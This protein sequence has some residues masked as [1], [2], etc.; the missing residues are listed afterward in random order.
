MIAKKIITNKPL[1]TSSI[2]ILF[3]ILYVIIFEFTWVTQNLF[4]KPT[5]L[6]ES[7]MSLL[8]EYNLVDAFF[9]TTAVI[10]PSILIA[11]LI[12][13]IFSKIFLSVFID[14][15]GI[16]NITTPFKYFSFFFFAL[17][18][19][20]L[21]QNS[22]FVEF[23]FTILFV[24]GLLLQIISKETDSIKEE[25]VIAAKSLGLSS[26]QIFSQVIW[27]SLKPN[28]YG[29]L[30]SIHTGAWVVVIIYEFIG[31]TNGVGAIYRLAFDYNDLLS[32]IS[33]GIFISLVIL[34]VNSLI[35]IVVS[36]LIFWK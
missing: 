14:Y 26:N 35:K 7:F 25:Y 13:E 32:I 1:K 3:V 16:K 12:I 24:I 30:V 20:F 36:K 21:F 17:L 33:L 29:K 11:I 22:L 18:L 9:E 2:T 31:S 34:L 4:P 10:F 28:V 19:N 8:S 27:K 15:N 6:L 5:L 23:V